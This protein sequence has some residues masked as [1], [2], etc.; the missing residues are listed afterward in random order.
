MFQLWSRVT[1]HN[2]KITEGEHGKQRA[3]EKQTET[4]GDRQIT[5]TSGSLKKP[6]CGSVAHPLKNGSLDI[7]LAENQ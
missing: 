7:T 1:V 4:D 3:S 6:T 2:T 5:I